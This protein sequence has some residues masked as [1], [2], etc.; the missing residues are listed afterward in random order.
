[1]FELDL[2]ELAPS[3]V[4]PEHQVSDVIDRFLLSGHIPLRYTISS[5]N[6]TLCLSMLLP[7]ARSVSAGLFHLTGLVSLASLF[8]YKLFRQF[9][10]VF[11][12]HLWRICADVLTV[13][14]VNMN[15]RTFRSG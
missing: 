13:F 6:G 3:G 10:I 15:T 8:R 11:A 12:M 5:A 9:C 14:V 2:T 1:M 4:G 7:D